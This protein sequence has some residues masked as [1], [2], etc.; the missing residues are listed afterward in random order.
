MRL[1]YAIVLTGGIATGKSA[2]A[3]LFERDGYT[4]IDADSIAHEMLERH[5]DEVTAR[6]GESVRSADGIDRKR[7]G[8]IVFADPMA[9]KKLEALLHPLIYEEIMRLGRIEEAKKRPYI[10]D[11][12]LFYEGGERYPAAKVLVVYAPQ[13]LQIE[14]A[15]RRDGLSEEEI[16]D[17]LAAQIDIAEKR[18]MADYLIDNSKDR[19]HLEEEYARIKARIEEDFA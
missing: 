7:L 8:A 5:A 1:E 4:V 3:S 16:L 2:V 13:A 18:Y 10:I 17:R 14:R 15:M 19:T 11:I 6:F 9:R 12:P